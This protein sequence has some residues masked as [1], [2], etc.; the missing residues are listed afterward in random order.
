MEEAAERLIDVV[1]PDAWTEDTTKQLQWPSDLGGMAF[2]SSEIAA[3]IGRLTAFGQCLPT[4]R[5]HLRTILPDAT[6]AEILGA[7]PLQGAEPAMQWL[8]G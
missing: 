3:R 7:V 2:G 1:G 4:A 8:R 5:R 6:D